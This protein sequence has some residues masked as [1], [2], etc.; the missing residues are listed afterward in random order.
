MAA[1]SSAFDIAARLYADKAT[2]LH[3]REQNIDGHPCRE[4]QIV[5]DPCDGSLLENINVQFMHDGIK[6]KG[7]TRHTIE[8]DLATMDMMCFY[9][10]ISTVN[11]VRVAGCEWEI[12]SVQRD[13]EMAT[14]FK[15]RRVEI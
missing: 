15:L 8:T 13:M 2:F 14:R 7:G 12:V 6:A 5:R 11:R 10:C 9:D 4:W 3:A 1:I